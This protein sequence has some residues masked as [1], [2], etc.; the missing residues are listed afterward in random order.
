MSKINL[1]PSLRAWMMTIKLAIPAHVGANVVFAF[2]FWRY[3]L[4]GLILAITGNTGN[5]GLTL[6]LGISTLALLSSLLYFLFLAGI[7]KL[8]LKILWS[9]PPKWIVTP[10]LKSL[11]IRD[12]GILMISA[13]PIVMI[14]MIYILSVTSLKEIFAD[15]RT[16]KITYDSFLLK[17]SWLWMISAAYLY[18]WCDKKDSG[19]AKK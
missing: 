2:E 1:L 7:Y 8:L 18:Q 11:I 5:D 16:L 19:N 4:L 12:W 13:F 14:F 6:F 17:F 15:L 10:S 9:N 3:S